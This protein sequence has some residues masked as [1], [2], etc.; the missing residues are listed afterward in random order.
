MCLFTSAKWLRCLLFVALLIAGCGSTT[1]KKSQPVQRSSDQKIGAE[2]TIYMDQIDQKAVAKAAKLGLTEPGRLDAFS[3]ETDY[4]DDDYLEYCRIVD[5]DG[6]PAI[7]REEYR[8]WYGVLPGEHHIKVRNDRDVHHEVVEMS[9][10]AQAGHWYSVDE[11]SRQFP[12][13]RFYVYDS[14]SKMA[15]AHVGHG[16]QAFPPCRYPTPRTIC[17]TPSDQG[18]AVQGH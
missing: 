7:P 9:F 17:L 15:V 18:S 11:T 1:E 8:T 5:I 16:T 3:C 10:V 4:T 14:T 13:W 2:T 6:V 12:E